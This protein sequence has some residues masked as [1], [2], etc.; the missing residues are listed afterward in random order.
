MSA[1]ICFLFGHEA[2][3][4]NPGNSISL[5]KQMCNFSEVFDYYSCVTVLTTQIL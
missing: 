5:Q 4:S 2:L 3:H 1:K